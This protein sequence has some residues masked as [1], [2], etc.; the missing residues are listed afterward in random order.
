MPIDVDR[1]TYAHGIGNA[2]CMACFADNAKKLS[3]LIRTAGYTRD[4]EAVRGPADPNTRGNPSQRGQQ[5]LV[6]EGIVGDGIPPSLAK[7]L[8][9]SPTPLMVAC[10]MGSENCVEL[11]L[12]QPGIVLAGAVDLAEADRW[13]DVSLDGSKQ[14]R[15]TEWQDATDECVSMVVDALW[16]RLRGPA[17]R[18][19][20]I[21]LFTR[22]LF[23]EVHFRPGQ[24]G[25]K[26]CRQ[27][28]EQRAAQQS[29]A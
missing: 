6:T 1:D 15:D 27:D 4:D 17:A 12:E 23:E 28:F 20:K 24:R 10:F 14:Q 9:L 18:V 29:C 21:A 22:R 7:L 19:G 11:L 13:H 5:A 16:E 2:M 8:E 26:R 25:A 3:E